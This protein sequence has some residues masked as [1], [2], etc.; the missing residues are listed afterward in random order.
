[1]KKRLTDWAPKGGCACKLGPA[2]LEKNLG[3][4]TW[5]TNKKVLVNMTGADDAGVYQ[6]S[7][8][9]A[10]VQTTDFFPPLV[11][12]AYQFGRIATANSLSDI[13]AMGG[14]PISAL[15]LVAF[16]VPLVEDGTLARV[17]QGA[18]DLLRELA[19]VVLGGH[20]IEQ[21]TPL[22][23][24]AVT[25]LVNPQSIWK[26]QGTKVG[27]VLV[28]TKPIGTGVLTT[29]LKGDLFPNGVKEAL[30]SMSTPNKMAYEVAKGFTIHACTDITGFSL[31]GHMTE[32]ARNSQIT[33]ELAHGKVPLFTDTLEAAT[34]G[35]VPAGTY[36]N[37]KSVTG[38]DLGDLADT[39]WSDVLFDPQTSGGLLFALPEE[40][41]D[42]LVKALQMDGVNQATCI[43][44][45]VTK[46]AAYVKVR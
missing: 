10:L 2:L 29:A 17:L 34:M 33:I 25:G 39:V 28:L 20:S 8:T 26:N 40:E 37:R 24:L 15:N 45:V 16:P 12:D 19:V 38:V 35:L 31:L 44:R 27:D 43:G 4:I 1:M 41:V 3:S 42:A 30:A 21:D 22:F 7:E 23:G 5:P 9:E 18:A 32:L 11:D 36:S 14:C 13:Y 6:L 46:E